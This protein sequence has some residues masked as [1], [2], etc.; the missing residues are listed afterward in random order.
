[1]SPSPESRSHASLGRGQHGFSLVFAIAITLVLITFATV[2]TLRLI[3]SQ[4]AAFHLNQ[5]AAGDVATSEALA[6]AKAEISSHADEM[7]NSGWDSMGL[8]A[9]ASDPFSAA[10]SS[11]EDSATGAARQLALV[12]NMR[13]WGTLRDPSWW[14]LPR[15]GTSKQTGDLDVQY[16]EPGQT[17]YID[18]TTNPFYTGS[19]TGSYN[20]VWIYRYSQWYD[21]VLAVSTYSVVPQSSWPLVP[22]ASASTGTTGWTNWAEYQDPPGTGP[23]YMW[24]TPIYKKVYTIQ[25]AGSQPARRVAVYVRMDLRN[26][27][28]P[29]TADGSANSILWHLAAVSETTPQTHSRVAQ[30]FLTI[31]LGG[32]QANALLD[33]ASYPAN[34]PGMAWIT[35]G[36]L[37]SPLWYLDNLG[38][39]V[40]NN[41]GATEFTSTDPIGRLKVVYDSEAG[42]NYKDP[43]TGGNMTP[44]GT[45]DGS[46]NA[47]DM[48]VSPSTGYPTSDGYPDM[49]LFPGALDDVIAAASISGR[50]FPASGDLVPVTV[51]NAP[52]NPTLPYMWDDLNNAQ[53]RQAFESRPQH[54]YLYEIPVTG[55]PKAGSATPISSDYWTYIAAV[56]DAQG[57]V[58]GWR[59]YFLAELNPDFGV[60]NQSGTFTSNSGYNIFNF[61]YLATPGPDDGGNQ[62]LFPDNPA[63]G[64]TYSATQEFERWA[65][66]VTN[67]FSAQADPTT[68]FFQ[69]GTAPPPAGTGDGTNGGAPAP[70]A[71]NPATPQWNGATDSLV[72][73]G[74]TSATGDWV[75]YATSTEFI[76]PALVGATYP[77]G[78][79]TNAQPYVWNDYAG[80]K[81]AGS[82]VPYGYNLLNGDK[83][84]FIPPRWSPLISPQES[85]VSLSASPKP[86]TGSEVR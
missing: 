16:L 5:S 2:I 81:F 66:F 24:D 50:V 45:D 3:A 15:V 67:T 77:N 35:A 36:N 8:N 28:N 76:D 9:S 43:N 19:A 32:A 57:N 12:A 10:T 46:D 55:N 75:V 86:Y 51:Q 54:V 22:K 29:D 62:V 74:I 78:T 4:Q 14:L 64:Y 21:N 82:G 69:V 65:R 30:D 42:L 37:P 13:N 39:V 27:Y 59:R 58:L 73:P 79:A 52:S 68:G 71:A 60:I 7:I 31:L 49:R 85:T 56:T 53:G 38:A 48:N 40:A 6:L 23:A 25:Q 1:M 44:D 26:Y 47:T 72:I 70:L 63:A 20:Q 84:N 18:A 17:G 80:G 33:E 41:P 11:L 83:I 61:G 34:P